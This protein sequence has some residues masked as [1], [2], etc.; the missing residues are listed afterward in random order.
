MEG[1]GGHAMVVYHACYGAI[2]SRYMWYHAW[3]HAT[4]LHHALV[5]H[6]ALLPRCAVL[7]L[8][9]WC[10]HGPHAWAQCSMSDELMPYMGNM[11]LNM[12]TEL[13]GL[14]A[15]CSC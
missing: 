8:L 7:V 5:L 15:P 14:S 10:W 6:Y 9:T 3:Y 2:P 12:A 4:V 13:L 11:L 1:M